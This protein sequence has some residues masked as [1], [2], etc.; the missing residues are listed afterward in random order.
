MNARPNQLSTVY[1][2]GLI[3]NAHPVFPA[4]GDG[5]GLPMWALTRVRIK[6]VLT[7]C[8]LKARIWLHS[9]FKCS[10]QRHYQVNFATKRRQRWYI[11]NV[12]WS[13]KYT[14]FVK[15]A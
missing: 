7:A 15:T 11:T 14:M 2:A 6:H 3:P 12:V 1:E 9:V 4:L 8:T 5:E 10:I 13:S